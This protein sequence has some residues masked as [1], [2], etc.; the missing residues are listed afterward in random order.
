MMSFQGI[1]LTVALYIV[2]F[3]ALYMLLSPG[4]EGM[5]GK[6]GKKDKKKPKQ[7]A[8]F[9]NDDDDDRDERRTFETIQEL[10]AAAKTF[11]E[12]QSQGGLRVDVS[13]TNKKKK[14]RMIHVKI[15][16]AQGIEFKGKARVDSDNGM[17]AARNM[18]AKM[19]AAPSLAARVDVAD[20]GFKKGTTSF[21]TAA[22]LTQGAATALATAKTQGYTIANVMANKKWDGTADYVHM[23]VYGRKPGEK[24]ATYFFRGYSRLDTD[25]TLLAAYQT[26]QQTILGLQEPKKFRA[27]LLGNR[28]PKPTT[29]P[30]VTAVTVPVGTVLPTLAPTQAPVATIPPTV[31]MPPMST[32]DVATPLATLPPLV[33]AMAM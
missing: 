29:A 8:S 22:A 28:V 9:P 30:T 19:F 14:G 3:L 31:P 24:K 6:K 1:N 32:S 25:A 10:A 15:K 5:K 20:R 4:H 16:G 18:L 27:F 11:V 23:V 33:T 12:S 26:I 17:K 7:V 21:D 2:A 13:G